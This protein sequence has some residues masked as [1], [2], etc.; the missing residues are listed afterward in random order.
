MILS[1][2]L[3]V[4]VDGIL[5]M[6]YFFGLV[7]K[8]SRFDGASPGSCQG[9]L[10]WCFSWITGDTAR[11][12]IVVVAVDWIGLCGPYALPVGVQSVYRDI[13]CTRIPVC[14]YIPPQY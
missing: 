6:H 4:S 1:F 12:A 5:R 14:S 13:L 7:A 3:F 11:I 9:R 2:S 8:Y 10:T